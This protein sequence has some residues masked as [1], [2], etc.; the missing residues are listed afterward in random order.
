MYKKYAAV[1]DQRGMNDLAVANAAEIPQS[2]LYDWKQRSVQKEDAEI[3]TSALLRIANVLEV[4][5]E[6]LI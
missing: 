5:I 3:S 4:P 2:T 1:R 6:E